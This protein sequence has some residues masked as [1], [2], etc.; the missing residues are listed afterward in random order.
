MLTKQAESEGPQQAKNQR[1]RQAVREL[2][3]SQSSLRRLPERKID[4]ESPALVKKEQGVFLE[5]S[6]HSFRHQDMVDGITRV[7]E[8][9]ASRVPVDDRI[10]ALDVIEEDCQ[11]QG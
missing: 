3:V 7:D 11:G 1:F 4:K 5:I 9:K 2:G 8:R 6:Q 10:R